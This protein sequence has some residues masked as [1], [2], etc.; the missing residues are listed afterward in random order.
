[1]ITTHAGVQDDEVPVPFVVG[2]R[3]EDVRS[4][5]KDGGTIPNGVIRLFRFMRSLQ[6]PTFVG[7]LQII[8][9]VQ[10]NG[11]FLWAPNRRYALLS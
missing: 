11:R 6:N 7:I 2:Y 8:T 10:T 4:P 1:M 9:R 5:H 3:Q